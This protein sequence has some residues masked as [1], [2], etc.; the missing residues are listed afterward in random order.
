M[1]RLALLSL[2]ALVISCFSIGCESRKVADD[3]PNGIR[4]SETGYSRQSVYQLQDRT[5]RQLAY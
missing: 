4:G 2:F 3:A 5:F 1:K